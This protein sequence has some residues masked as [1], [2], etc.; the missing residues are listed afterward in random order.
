MMPDYPRAVARPDSHIEQ[1]RRSHA[2]L[3]TTV[4]TVDPGVFTAFTLLPD[5][6]V[7]HVLTHLA[8]NADSVVRRL[9]AVSRGQIVEQYDGG[10]TA[11][12]TAIER[13]AL[14]PPDEIVDDLIRADDAVDATLETFQKWDEP[15]SLVSDRTCSHLVLSRWREV[16]VHH[17]DLSLNSYTFED[18]P[19][20]LVD[21]LLPAL[22]FGLPDRTD[23]RHLM[24][25]AMR[26]AREPRLEAWN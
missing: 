26:R 7:A 6:R 16:E 9:E 5:W 24:A 18:W 3:H 1:L 4:T 12:D 17:V 11:R 8:R 25:W 14:R 22:L 13:G 20:E 19:I 15:F 2:R 10:Q 21:R 23:P